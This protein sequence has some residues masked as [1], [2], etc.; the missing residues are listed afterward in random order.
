MLV[1][2]NVSPTKESKY[3]R[4]TS[5]SENNGIIINVF[6]I[7]PNTLRFNFTNFLKISYIYY[8]IATYNTSNILINVPHLSYANL[9][10][11]ERA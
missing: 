9:A 2:E 1:G 4:K 8:G 6:Q 7:L 5:Q 3:R 10:R 11:D